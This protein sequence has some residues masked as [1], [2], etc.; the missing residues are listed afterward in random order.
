MKS[1]KDIFYFLPAFYQIMCLMKSQNNFE[2]I[3]ILKIWLLVSFWGV[4]THFGEKIP[5]KMQF[6]KWNFWFSPILPLW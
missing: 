2:K 6:P 5:E 4:K 1:S 3:T